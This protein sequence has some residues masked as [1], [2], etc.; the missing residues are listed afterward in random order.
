[1]T[2][3][4]KTLAVGF[5]KEF[6]SVLCNRS[7]NDWD[8]PADWTHEEK[9]TFMREFLEWNGTPEDFDEERL[10]I[11]DACVAQFLAHKIASDGLGAGLD[12][13]HLHEAL[14]RT[15][16]TLC[17]IDDHLLGHPFV[18]AHPEIVGEIMKASKIFHGVYQQLGSMTL[19]A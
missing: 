15:H 7:C 3:K 10:W 13:F 1:M 12:K 17:M 6:G 2:E 4:E 5:L 8:F 14:D 18:I 11:S 19:Y 16:V 9:C